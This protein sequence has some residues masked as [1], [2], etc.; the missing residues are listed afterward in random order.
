MKL[1]LLL[2]KN[3]E[4]YPKGQNLKV[5]ILRIEAFDHRISLSEKNANKEDGSVNDYMVNSSTNN[6]Q[7]DDVFGSFNVANEEESSSDSESDYSIQNNP[8]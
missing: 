1:K 6:S 2:E 8:C 5:E 4:N 3:A 7:L